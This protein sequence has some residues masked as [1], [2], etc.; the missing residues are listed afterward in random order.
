MELF[1]HLDYVKRVKVKRK[2]FK[3]DTKY[4]YLFEESLHSTGS[5]IYV[6]GYSAFADEL[7]P[8]THDALSNAR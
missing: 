8:G 6:L 2:H 3:L 7:R 5:F 1:S 4:A